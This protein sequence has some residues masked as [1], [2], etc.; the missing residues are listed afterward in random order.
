MLCWRILRVD[1]L[2]SCCWGL[3]GCS[4]GVRVGGGGGCEVG[5]CV[6]G[7]FYVF[8]GYYGG[9]GCGLLGG[10]GGEVVG[11]RSMDQANVVVSVALLMF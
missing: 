8:W 6:V 11:V 2:L 1:S 9:K 5:C 7:W 10:C 3:R 4:W